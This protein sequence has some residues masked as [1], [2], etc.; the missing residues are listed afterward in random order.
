MEIDTD[1]EPRYSGVNKNISLP[2]N[3]N[4]DKQAILNILHNHFLLSQ[5]LWPDHDVV[6]ANS[7]SGTTVFTLRNKI[8]HFITHRCGRVKFVNCRNG[9]YIG[10]KVVG[11]PEL[12]LNYFVTETEGQ[13]SEHRALVHY[14][15]EEDK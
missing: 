2:S 14:K 13:S 15:R 11:L 7:M 8:L 6:A 3:I 12:M 1:E 9:I 5:I 4:T 10:E